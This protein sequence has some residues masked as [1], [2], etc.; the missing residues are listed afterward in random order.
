[1]CGTTV[2][3]VARPHV[4]PRRCR[5]STQGG[6]RSRLLPAWCSTKLSS[7]VATVGSPA[8]DDYAALAL[9]CAAQQRFVGCHADARQACFLAGQ[10]GP[11]R[12]GTGA[13][14]L[15]ALPTS[16]D[17]NR[18]HACGQCRAT[19]GGDGVGVRAVGRLRLE[20]E[21]PAGAGGGPANRSLRQVKLVLRTNVIANT[22]AVKSG[23]P[24]IRRALADVEAE[25]ITAAAG[26]DMYG[27]QGVEFGASPTGE[28]GPG[29]TAP[30]QTPSHT[31]DVG[32]VSMG[33]T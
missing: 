18:Q 6:A 13:R 27:D 10:S 4:P 20:A 25:D 24:G 16:V 26:L 21:D 2:L 32:P 29:R 23:D 12:S 22:G 30:V 19:R 3:V 31:H 5:G 1:M 33:D 17:V 15:D 28:D 7:G 8:G 14:Q 11:P 9:R